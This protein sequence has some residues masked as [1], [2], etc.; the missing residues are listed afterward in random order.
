MQDPLQLLHSSLSGKATRNVP[1]AFL[2]LFGDHDANGWN[3]VHPHATMCTPH[4]ETPAMRIFYA[5]G[6][7][8]INSWCTP[9]VTL[10]G[11]A[12]IFRY[13]HVQSALFS[14]SWHCY[15]KR[16]SRILGVLDK[17]ARFSSWAH[18]Y[19]TAFKPPGGVLNCK[20]S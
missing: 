7:R 20:S 16:D 11:P 6:S 4:E 9:K 18:A 1:G 13:C 14:R 19:E 5:Y 8:E 12:T 2:V 17:S 15:G 3:D 10:E